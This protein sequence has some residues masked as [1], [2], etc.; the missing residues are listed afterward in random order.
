M[1]II[2]PFGTVGKPYIKSGHNSSIDC[3]FYSIV[4]FNGLDS[5]ERMERVIKKE[6]RKKIEKYINKLYLNINK[7]LIL[8]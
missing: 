2:A 5:V 7:M 3:Y 4:L 8:V 1:I 6:G